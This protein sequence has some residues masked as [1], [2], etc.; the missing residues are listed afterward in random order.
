MSQIDTT[1]E[2]ITG[3]AAGV[4]F[5]AVPPTTSP[6][7]SAP[8]VVAWHLLDP[9][10]T[11]AAF[12]AALPLHG[13]DAWR[14]YLGLPMTG[15]RLPLGGWDELMRLGYEDA[16]LNLW[17]PV[18]YGAAEEF[19]PAFAALR[20]QLR[21]DTGP[22]GVMGGS[23]GAA[24]AQLVL[25][26]GEHA[27]GAAVLVSPLVQLR[28]AVEAMA[29]HFGIIYP[30]SDESNA[31]TDWLDFVTRARGDRRPEPAGSL[32][33]RRRARRPRVPRAGSGARRSAQEALRKRRPGRAGHRPGYGPR[34][35]RGARNR[36]RATDPTRRDR[37]AVQWFQ[38]YLT[39]RQ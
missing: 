15:S 30:W 36:P 11:E 7:D 38:R 10:R 26:E 33:H 19:S 25:A 2:P 31:L 17:M 20:R 13:L 23:I 35:R 16:V 29:R 12:A 4:P 37:H 34:P 8:V 14:I 28:R 1:P 22:V 9:P 27:L 5:L 32:A 6:R 3:R 39:D 18:I 21:L 24:V